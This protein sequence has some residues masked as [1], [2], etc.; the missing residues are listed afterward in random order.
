VT[1]ALRA[2]TD[3]LQR[4][5]NLAIWWGV[6]LLPVVL[7]LL[8]PLLIVFFVIRWFVRRRKRD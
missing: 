7:I 2:L 1:E 4:L 3:T 8:L 6:Y 5:G